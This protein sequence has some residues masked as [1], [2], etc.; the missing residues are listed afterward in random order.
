M[1]EMLGGVKINQL[2][3]ADLRY[4]HRGWFAAPAAA[5]TPPSLRSCRLRRQDEHRRRVLV[6]SPHLLD[7]LSVDFKH[8]VLAAGTDLLDS[9]LRCPVAVAVYFSALQELAAIEHRLECYEIDVAIVPTVLLTGARVVN[10]TEKT[11]SGSSASI[12]FTSKVLPTSGDDDEI[13]THGNCA[14]S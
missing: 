7:A 12:G 8:Y 3:N 6:D 10:E 5:C 2:G 4:F 13:A 9:L 11:S 14:A 1:V